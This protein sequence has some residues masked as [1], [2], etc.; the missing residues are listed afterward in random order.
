MVSA[1]FRVTKNILV[2][3]I[4]ESGQQDLLNALIIGCRKESLSIV[5]DFCEGLFLQGLP[6]EERY[7][8]L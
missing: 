4:T 3:Y 5:G 8:L 2:V 1:A 7:K 6:E